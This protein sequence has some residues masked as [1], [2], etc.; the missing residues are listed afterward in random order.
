MSPIEYKR[1]GAG[2]RSRRPTSSLLQLAAVERLPR[3]MNEVWNLGSA[4]SKKNRHVHTR[5]ETVAFFG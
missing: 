3:A 1:G 4:A 5:P 2:P